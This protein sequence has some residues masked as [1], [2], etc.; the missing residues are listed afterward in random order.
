VSKGAV[1]QAANKLVKEGTHFVNPQEP[2]VIYQVAALTTDVVLGYD[3]DVAFDSA[4]VLNKCNEDGVAET[5]AFYVATADGDFDRSPMVAPLSRHESDELIPFS[6]KQMDENLRTINSVSLNATIR[7]CSN[8][9][10]CSEYFVCAYCNDIEKIAHYGTNAILRQTQTT[11]DQCHEWTKIDYDDASLTYMQK[12]SSSNIPATNRTVLS[13]KLGRPWVLTKKDN[14]NATYVIAYA[15]FPMFVL[16]ECDED[17]QVKSTQAFYLAEAE[18]GAKKNTSA[19]HSTEIE[20]DYENEEDEDEVEDYYYEDE[21]DENE[22]DEDEEDEV[23]DYYYYYD[24]E[25]SMNATSTNATYEYDYVEEV[26]TDSEEKDIEEPEGVAPRIRSQD[27]P[28]ETGKAW[29][30]KRMMENFKLIDNPSL[31]KQVRNCTM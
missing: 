8:P 14:P 11:L 21:E 18:G 3:S 30:L 29:L 15:E 9:H 12:V 28:T 19:C 16:N 27:T 22:E 5:Q 23:E 1:V 7:D 20:E 24:D 25:S 17:D 2:G 4:F 13:P 6:R 31:E 26:K 10:K